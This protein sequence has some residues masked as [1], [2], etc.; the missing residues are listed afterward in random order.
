MSSHGTNPDLDRCHREQQSVVSL[1]L[2]GHPEQDGLRMALSDW[3]WEE[4]EIWYGN[5]D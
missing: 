1:L 2:S 5:G 4:L 3:I